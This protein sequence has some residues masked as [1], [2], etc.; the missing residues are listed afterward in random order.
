MLLAKG[1]EWWFE[2]TPSPIIKEILYDHMY[3]YAQDMV[4]GQEWRSEV[5]Y[6]GALTPWKSTAVAFK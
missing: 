1:N 6:K 4:E 3:K 2:S 5:M